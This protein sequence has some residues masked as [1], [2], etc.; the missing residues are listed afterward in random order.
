MHITPQ[1]KSLFSQVCKEVVRE[2]KV[3]VS[4]VSA[5]D[6]LCVR[7][8]MSLWDFPQFPEPNHIDSN[9]NNKSLPNNYSGSLLVTG[10]WLGNRFLS[11]SHFLP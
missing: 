2:A 7:L 11:L 9:N 5:A 3:S 6:G 10:M 4:V 8:E 1:T